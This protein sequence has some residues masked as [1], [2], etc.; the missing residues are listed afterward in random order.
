MSGR[1]SFAP[2]VALQPRAAERPSAC[3][4]QPQRMVTITAQPAKRLR[5][6]AAGSRRGS[7]ASPEI[8]MSLFH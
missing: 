5:E 8:R 6:L 3:R 7:A 4:R 2:S 1:T